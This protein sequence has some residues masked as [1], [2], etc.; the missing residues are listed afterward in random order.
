MASIDAS[1]D[2]DMIQTLTFASGSGTCNIRLYR[3]TYE[4]YEYSGTVYYRAGT[5]GSWTTLSVSGDSTTFPVSDTTMQVAHDWN[6]SGDDYM[7]CSFYGQSTNLTGIA[8]SQKAVLSGDIGKYLCIAMLLV[9][10]TLT[11]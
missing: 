1:Q 4:G 3:G 8:M 6:K 9:V 11:R 2:Y 7:T 5:S 10:K